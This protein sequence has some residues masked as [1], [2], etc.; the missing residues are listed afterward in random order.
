MG[1]W[2]V[3]EEIRGE[4]V[5]EYGVKEEERELYGCLM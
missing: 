3:V 1:E 2:E 5:E 4:V